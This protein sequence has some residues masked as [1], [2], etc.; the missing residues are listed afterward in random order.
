MTDYYNSEHSS[1]MHI[2]I[3]FISAKYQ[4]RIYSLTYSSTFIAKE[5][6]FTLKAQTA[7]A[8]LKPYLTL[9]SFGFFSI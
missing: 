1:T 9:L 7:C 3:F 2:F 4:V 6:H 5:S 8:N